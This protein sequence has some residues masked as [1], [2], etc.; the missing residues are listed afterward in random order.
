MVEDPFSYDCYGSENGWTCEIPLSSFL[1]VLIRQKLTSVFSSCYQPRGSSNFSF[2]TVKVV[3]LA[4][5]WAVGR[6][7]RLIE[8]TRV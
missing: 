4:W 2:G 6:G 5:N 3:D 8:F 1:R 7:A